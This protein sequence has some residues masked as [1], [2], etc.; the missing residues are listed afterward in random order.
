M[1]AILPRAVFRFGLQVVKGIGAMRDYLHCGP[2]IG[3]VHPERCPTISGTK[4]ER[5]KPSYRFVL[6]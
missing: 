4:A 5:H 1:Q 6:L 3:A 2:E